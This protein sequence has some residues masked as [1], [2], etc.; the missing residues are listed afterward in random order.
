MALLTVGKE[1]KRGGGCCR[2]PVYLDFQAP[3]VAVA[4]GG[5]APP[6]YTITEDAQNS[7]ALFPKLFL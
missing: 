5:D 1:R 7:P 2:P 3:P 6:L 4:R